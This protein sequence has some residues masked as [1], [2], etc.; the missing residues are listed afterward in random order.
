M[1][2]SKN[3]VGPSKG[4]AKLKLQKIIGYFQAQGLGKLNQ[5]LIEK[6]QVP[7]VQI[8]AEGRVTQVVPLPA[9]WSDWLWYQISVDVH[10]GDVIVPLL[11]QAESKEFQF[12]SHSQINQSR[13]I[14]YVHWACIKLAAFTSF[15]VKMKKLRYRKTIN[16]IK[17]YSFFIL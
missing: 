8:L 14:E 15:I 5:P 2:G 13:G 16:V 6:F 4:T 10:T 1:K 17:V 12:R 3:N 7:I 9:D 11:V